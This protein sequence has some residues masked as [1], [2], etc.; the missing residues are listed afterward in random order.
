MTISPRIMGKVITVR[1][2]SRCAGSEA[3][4]DG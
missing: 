1:R 2:A 4:S 3:E